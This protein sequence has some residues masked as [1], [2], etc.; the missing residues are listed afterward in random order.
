MIAV[1][2]DANSFEGSSLFWVIHHVC[3]FFECVEVDGQPLI[4]SY[5][6]H[7]AICAGTAS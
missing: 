1:D 2:V 4:Q 3:E 6:Q 7:L 5:S